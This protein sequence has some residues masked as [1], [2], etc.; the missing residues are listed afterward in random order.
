M[1]QLR[2]AFGVWSLWRLLL[3]IVGFFATS[4]FSEAQPET[5]LAYVG[6]KAC[7]DCHLEAYEAW[8]SSHHAWAWREPS[9]EIV[10][11]DFDGSA[12]THEGIDYHFSKGD[13]GEYRVSLTD[14]ISKTVRNYVV[15]ATAGVAPLQQ[16]L[17][18]TEP[19]R[20][21]GLAAPGVGTG[22]YPPDLQD[23]AVQTVLQQAEVLSA[24]WAA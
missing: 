15:E 19:G 11:A 1:N 9:P 12:F 6:S 14:T 16:Y 24:R 4:T 21:R 20:L 3:V 13:S 5:H 8:S 18:E 22:P 2:G 7:A 17:I 10:L 23:D